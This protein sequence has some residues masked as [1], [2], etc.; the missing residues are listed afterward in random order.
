LRLYLIRP[1]TDLGG[2]GGFLKF[3]SESAGKWIEAGERETKAAL[4]RHYEREVAAPDGST[5]NAVFRRQPS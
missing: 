3:D 1:S 4:G 5:I 2:L